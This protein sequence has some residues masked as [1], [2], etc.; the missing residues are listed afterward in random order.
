MDK[1]IIRTAR[2]SDRE[3]VV[4][5]SS[6][7]WQGH[8]YLPRVWDQWLEEP[9]GALLVAEL[10]GQPVGTDKITLLAPGEVWLEGLRVDPLHRGKG[11]AHALNEK[12]MQIIAGLKP[13]TVRFGTVSDNQASRHLGETLGFRLI[14]QCQRMLAEALEGDLPSGLLGRDRDVDEIMVFLDH[15][16]NF[17]RTKG[18][19]AWGWT[20]KV[21]DR[22]FV[23][24]VVAE[25]GA[26]IARRGK[27]IG[28][29]A[30]YLRQRH[31]PKATLGFIDGSEREIVSLARHFRIAAGRRGFE[32]LLTMVPE[33]LVPALC[34]AGFRQEEPIHVVVYELS[35][36]R[37]RKALQTRGDMALG[38]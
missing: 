14:F 8:D 13:T 7:I 23:E 1:L 4:S 21:L 34:A 9:F 31:G 12:A 30:L 18:Q 35:G 2:R 10:A 15:S 37:L 20:F 16:S 26:L 3:A 17:K 22:P 29:L 5:F 36:E 27:R 38:S 6:R 25:H 32:Q 24:R 19:F 11:I 33:K 28:G